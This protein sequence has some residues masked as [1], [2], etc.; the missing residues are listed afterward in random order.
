MEELLKFIA[1][2]GYVGTLAIVWVYV[3]H[4]NML[5]ELKVKIEMIERAIYQRLPGGSL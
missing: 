2:G 4:S 1:A 5:S 3:K